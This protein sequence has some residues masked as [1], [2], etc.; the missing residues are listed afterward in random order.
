[1]DLLEAIS[2][3]PHLGGASVMAVA[4]LTEITV[5][6]ASCLMHG[7]ALSREALLPP[8]SWGKAY[9]RWPKKG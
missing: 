1:M 3:S 7:E 9:K 6:L 5:N 4:E 2:L 8:L